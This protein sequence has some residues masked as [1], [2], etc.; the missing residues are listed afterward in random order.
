MCVSEIYVVFFFFNDT[1]TTEI[2]TLSLHDALPISDNDGKPLPRNPFA[3]ARVRRAMSIAINREALAER[4]MEGT[5]KPAGQ[6]LP[7]G[8]F[9]YNPEVRVPPFDPDGAKRML[10][11]AGYPQGFQIG[12]ASC[13]ERV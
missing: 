12:R 8:V 4:V 10:A 7:E 6:W 3:D 2:Y 1:A 5:A 13:R 11:E 9:G